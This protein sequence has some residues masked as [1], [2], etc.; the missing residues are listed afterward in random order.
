MAMSVI[1]ASGKQALGSFITGTAYFIFGIPASWYFAFSRDM[2]LRGLWIGPTIAVAYNTVFYNII[3]ACI[4]WPALVKDIKQ[5]E[6]DE[7]ELRKKLAEAEAAKTT[8]DG[9]V[10]LEAGP[11]ATEEAAKNSTEDGFSRNEIN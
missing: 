1:R 4:D 7:M 9:F 3:I 5:R 6:R 8:D 11:A 10:A 2:G